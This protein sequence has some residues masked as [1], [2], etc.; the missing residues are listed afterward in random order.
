M[1]AHSLAL[2]TTAATEVRFEVET[3][4]P[5]VHGDFRVRAY[6][7]LER[8]I[9]HLALIS[10]PVGDTPIVRVHS[11]CLTG[12][13]F[14]SLKCECGPQLEESLE[15]IAREGGVVIYLR[16]HEGRG[17]GLVNKLRAYRLQEDGLDTVEANEALDLPVD[18]RDYG[19]AAAMLADLGVERVRLLTNNPEKI[20]QLG[21]NGI[22][23]VERL[24]LVI[25]GG[26][27]SDAYLATKRDRMGH[28]LAQSA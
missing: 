3:L 16:G 1:N 14:G 23:V 25:A 18:D 9:D 21:A 26:E 7:E 8:G 2:V 28:L 15:I 5:T 11:E 12:E 20:A 17:I 27:H 19:A 22:S 24:P 4:I 6:R 10:D 13:A